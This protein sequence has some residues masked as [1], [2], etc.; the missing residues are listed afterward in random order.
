MVEVDGAWSAP[1]LT[2]FL[3]EALVPLRLSCH[4]PDG[5]LWI[6]SLWY[7]YEDGAFFCATQRE[8]DVARFLRR[9]G[10]VAFEVSTN[11][12]PYMG[13]RGKGTASLTADEEK[14]LLRSLLERYLGGTESELATLLLD[15][16]RDELIITVEPDRL[17]TWDFT[18]RMQTTLTDSPAV[19]QP[20]PGSPLR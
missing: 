19:R 20:E 15:E 9:D 11:T 14:T 13:V 18:D 6:L 7:R 3:E 10:A 5:G 1:Q 12:P 17:Y 4:R 8:S 2:T 16:E